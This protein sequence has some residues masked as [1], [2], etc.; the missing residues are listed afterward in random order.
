M[1][2]GFN[3][4]LEAQVDPVPC[5]TIRRRTAFRL[6][7]L[8]FIFRSGRAFGFLFGLRLRSL[9]VV[10]PLP[11]SDRFLLS[12]GERAPRCRRGCRFGR[13]RC[14]GCRSAVGPGLRVRIFRHRCKAVML[15]PLALFVRLAPPF[16]LVSFCS[17]A[18]SNAGFET[19]VRRPG[20]L[21][22]LL[23]CAKVDDR[24]KL[25]VTRPFLT[26]RQ[27]SAIINGRPR[28]ERRRCLSRDRLWRRG[29]RSG[30]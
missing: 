26:G 21:I 5:A 14:F 16:I 17:T 22:S 19:V 2:D 30:S 23:C 28:R 10:F 4:V 29:G 15:G 7:E 1:G 8:T 24:L 18:G 13:G 6:V 12:R 3:S 9:L 27:R 11:G 25:G 20:V